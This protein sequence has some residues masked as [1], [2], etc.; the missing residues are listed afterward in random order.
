ML[1]PKHEWIRGIKQPDGS[2]P[3][4]LVVRPKTGRKKTIGN[5]A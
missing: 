3:K 5:F 2:N 1:S 4:A